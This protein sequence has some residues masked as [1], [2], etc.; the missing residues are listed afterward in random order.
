MSNPNTVTAEPL[1]KLLAGLSRKDV[2]SDFDVTL[3]RGYRTRKATLSEDVVT[4]HV[5]GGQ[6]IAVYP[7]V[8]FQTRSAVLDF[9][10]HENALSFDAMAAR[11]LPLL[12][13]LVASGL[14]PLAF[15][16]GG[17]AGIHIWLIWKEWQ[18]ARTARRF[19]TRVISRHGLRPGARGLHV[20]EVEI[21]PKQDRVE[22]DAIGSAIALPLARKSLPLD[23]VLAPIVDKAHWRWPLDSIYSSNLPDETEE[24][25]EP[26]KKPT[27]SSEKISTLDEVLEGD[28]TQAQAAL[29]HLTADDY[30]SWIQIGLILKHSFA[31]KGFAVWDDWSEMSPDKY[32]GAAKIKQLWN[33]LKPRGD[34]GLGSLFHWACLKGWNGPTNPVIRE[35]NARYGILTHA[36]RTMII[37]K[38]GGQLDREVFKWLSKPTFLDRLAAEKIEASGGKPGSRAR[39]WLDHPQAA[40]YYALDFDPSRPP[41]HNG[42]TWNVWRGFGV[43][44]IP[45]NWDLL[46]DHIFH[47]IC[48]G[49]QQAD[50]WLLNWMALGVQ[51]PGEP[52]GTAPVLHGLP[53]TGK[54]FLAHAYGKLF[55]RHFTIVT[56][57]SHVSGR[58]N[59]HLFGKR[60][61]FIDEGLFGGD[62][63]TAGIIKTRVTEPYLMLEIKGVDPIEIRN[64][65]IF[66]VASNE[67]S[68]VPADIGDRRWQVF[69]VGARNRED[70]EYFANITHQ[71]ENGGSS[72][73]L[74]DLLHRDISKEPNPRKIIRNIGL[75][76]QIMRAV[77]PED[78]YIHQLLDNGFLPQQYAPGNSYNAT[79]IKA[80]YEEMRAL[81]GAQYVAP[82]AFGRTLR[83][84]IPGIRTSVH[85]DYINRK[86]EYERSTRYTFPPLL[87]CR[88]AFERHIGQAVPWTND[89]KDWAGAILDKIM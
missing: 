87:D 39:F 20:N 43:E 33:S 44:P 89:L 76:E 83:R 34:L 10:N 59:R 4:R 18:S 31:E 15:R 23:H 45:G 69:E 78:R 80:M 71:L 30:Q 61:V 81:A 77:G 8:G 28:L 19:L 58:F 32:P 46:Q 49:N 25:R 50:D 66:M 51:R 12:H 17:G 75:F 27:P 41:G 63:E 64:R 57:H 42:K 67:A 21:Y 2:Y 56:D 35:M 54:G 74:Y 5:S 37:D 62:H 82:N 79:T 68:I 60:F 85:G 22:G 3:G 16:S 72:A 40:H 55:G 13:D 6:P 38:G 73:M 65:M 86:A 70:Q 29:R 48:G 53:G 52:I 84:I 9:D 7:V 24:P 47:N 14:K 11:V 88:R 26:A 36:N 1:V